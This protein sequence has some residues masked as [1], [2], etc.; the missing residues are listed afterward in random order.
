LCQCL[1]LRQIASLPTERIALWQVGHAQPPHQVQHFSAVAHAVAGQVNYSATKALARGWLI[2][3][4]FVAVVQPPLGLQLARDGSELRCYPIQPLKHTA[5]AA[6][7]HATALRQR[8]WTF[9]EQVCPGFHVADHVA[10]GFAQ[11]LLAEVEV[12]V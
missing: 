2:K 11:G 4:V 10:E 7:V 6:L 5:D 1:L 8:L 12:A 9:V 3:V